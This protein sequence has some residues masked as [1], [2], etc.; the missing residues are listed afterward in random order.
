[1]RSECSQKRMRTIIFIA[2][3]ACF[4]SLFISSAI[5]A[6]DGSP[7][8]EWAKGYGGPY[9]DGV[10]S[11]AKAGD[12]GYVLTGYTSTL[13]QGSDLWLFKVDGEG[14]LVWQKILG[15][16]GED[17]G[18]YVK[19]VSDGGYAVTGSTASLGIGEERLWLL[20]TDKNGSLQWSRVFGGF[21]S[22]S[23]DGGWSLDETGDG[24]YIVTGYTQSFGSGKKDL[25][26]LRTDAEGKLQW[27]KTFGGREDDVG[28][29][30]VRTGEGGYVVA[31]RTASF[32]K[33]GDDIWLLKT[34]PQGKEEW[35]KTFG[36]KSDDAAFQI[37][38]ADGGLAVVGRTESGIRDKRIILLKTDPAGQRL[39]DRT[40][41][42]SSGTSLQRTSDGGFILAGRLDSENTGRDAL[43]I[44]TD[45]DGREQ[46]SLPITADGDDIG[47]F[48]LESADGSYFFAGIGNP[49]RSEA[50]DAWLQKYGTAQPEVD[51]DA[52]ANPGNETAKET[53]IQG[54]SE[55]GDD[56]ENSSESGENLSK[57]EKIF[58]VR[59]Q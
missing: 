5:S 31:G 24:G 17:A 40:Y 36:G 18:Y 38:E 56:I 41:H 48:A 50:E 53:I 29:S 58:K 16:S 52:E 21:V 15:G 33:G 1:M 42:G 44:R 45:S 59:L 57:L 19:E 54:S 55:P 43:L 35:N 22:S 4:S 39:W 28:M 2:F 6:P 7:R 12:G 46:W 23:G 51:G 9:S 11:L 20:K 13:G 49:S 37:I 3:I 26:L 27:E 8:E 30:V 14:N 47:T 10:W 34:D 25:W 32:G